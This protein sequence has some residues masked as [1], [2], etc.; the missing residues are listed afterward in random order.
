VNNLQLHSA[1]VLFSVQFIMLFQQKDLGE[2]MHMAIVNNRES[3]VRLLLKNAKNGVSLREFL[4]VD[5]LLKLYN[6]VRL[7][8]YH[9]LLL[10]FIWHVHIVHVYS[11][12]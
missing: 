10:F 2:M 6:H 8:L 12:Y 11:F 7:K 3:F 1:D 9:F 5:A 4:T